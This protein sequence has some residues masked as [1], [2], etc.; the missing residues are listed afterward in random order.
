[1]LSFRDAMLT[2]VMMTLVCGCEPPP[3]DEPIEPD[4]A[5]SQ[6]LDVDGGDPMS[7][8]QA[9]P[10]DSDADGPPVVHRD[11]SP[12][13]V[14]KPNGGN[15]PGTV[16]KANVGVGKKGQGYGGGFV[17]EPAK[18]YFKIRER[19][20]FQIQVPQALNTYKALDPRGKGPKTT[21]DF[22]ENVIKQNGIRLPE[23][24]SG[25]SY[26]YDPE[27]EELNVRRPTN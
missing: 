4:D 23:L 3:V 1:M 6:V 25:Q 12:P 24:P 22:M 9:K 21:E 8:H 5:T 17:S 20:V 11:A 14:T 15:Q 7:A 19:T 27:T 2:V 26:E 13:S 18:V 10:H 16:T